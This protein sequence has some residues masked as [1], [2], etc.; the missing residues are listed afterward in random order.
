[1]TERS[2]NG[3]RATPMKPWLYAVLFLPGAYAAN[4]FIGRIGNYIDS[5]VIPPT[6]AVAIFVFTAWKHL[7][8]GARRPNP[9]LA[10]LLLFVPVVNLVWI[11]WAIYPLGTSIK[12]DAKKYEL[13][14]EVSDTFSRACCH[15]LIATFA[16]VIIFVLEGTRM[17]DSAIPYLPLLPI[18]ITTAAVLILWLVI[19]HVM[20]FHYSRIINAIALKKQDGQ[21][22]A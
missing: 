19:L 18:E 21:T 9:L 16:L 10:A 8:R 13:A 5:T 14:D 11:Y 3:A 12:A 17:P 4:L 1:M 22:T 6:L 2:D 7:D 20:F 15:L